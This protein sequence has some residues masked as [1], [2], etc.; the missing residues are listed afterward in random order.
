MQAGK[1]FIVFQNNPALLAAGVDNIV[2]HP[3]TFMSIR[4]ITITSN[5]EVLTW[6]AWGGTQWTE[7]GTDI[8]IVQRN[9]SAARE[10]NAHAQLNPT[11]SDV[12]SPFF[13]NP[14]ELIGQSGVGTK[15]YIDSELLS[16]PFKLMRDVSYL[17]RITNTDTVTRKYTL[18]LNMYEE[19]N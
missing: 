7:N 3:H 15:A 13:S 1:A 17:I 16:S 10:L 14:V 5:S 19:E 12:G 6:Q 2:I 4:N 9:Q 8:D 11:I 18:S